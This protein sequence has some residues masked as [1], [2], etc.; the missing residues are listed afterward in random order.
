MNVAPDDPGSPLNPPLLPG[1]LLGGAIG[2][3]LLGATDVVVAAAGSGQDTPASTLLVCSLVWAVCGALL[4][5]PWALL[6]ARS[7]LRNRPSLQE[8]PRWWGANIAL[9]CTTLAFVWVDLGSTPAL[10]AAG[11]L[12]LCGGALSALLETARSR[13]FG[14]AGVLAALSIW[15]VLQQREDAS[16]WPEG[17]AKSVL[18]VTLEGMRATDLD[19]LSPDGA[20]AHWQ[21]GGTTYRR[22]LLPAEDPALALRS[23]WRGEAGWRA[24]GLHP[25]PTPTAAS[26]LSALGWSANGH[27]G[28]SNTE[29]PGVTQWTDVTAWIPVWRATR[30]GRLLGSRTGRTQARRVVASAKKRLELVEARPTVLWVHLADGRFPWHPPPPWDTAFYQGDPWD[31]RQASRL[32]PEVQA[33]WPDVLDPA[34]V[35]AQ[36]KGALFSADDALRA[37]VETIPTDGSWAVVVVGTAGPDPLVPSEEHL[38]TTTG[39]VVVW[40]PGTLPSGATVDAPI[41]AS[42]VS[43]TLLELAGA[44]T[45]A[46]GQ[47]SLVPLAFG[48]RARPF[49]RSSHAGVPFVVSTGV[50]W[51]SEEGEPPDD[52]WREAA[53]QVA[54]ALP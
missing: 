43:A 39:S 13:I 49:A 24:Q 18:L 33:V 20:I 47:A 16:G 30:T 54:E 51:S 9:A 36:R 38:V 48:R 14:M 52:R 8:N 23:L 25:I 26:Q 45:E 34:W 17:N 53:T 6:L 11:P 46:T 31:S 15:A 22:V 50:V 12:L 29:D 5:L 44:P 4:A 32:P 21:A 7:P 37:L 19:A 41:E 27:I 35:A 3:G 2:G 10:L 28:A 42:T 40:A 1:I